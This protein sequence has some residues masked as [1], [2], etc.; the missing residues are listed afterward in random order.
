MRGR[1]IAAFLAGMG[2]GY[3]T[4]NE[5]KKDRERQ[6]KIDQ[7][8]FDKADREKQAYEERDALKQ[9]LKA[10]PTTTNTS[11]R[12]LSTDDVRGMTGG[13]ADP[14]APDYVS[15]EAAAHYKANVTG[16]DQVKSNASAYA[17]MGVGDGL[18]GQEVAAKDGKLEVTDP[19]KTK[20]IPAWKIMEQKAKIKIQSGIPEEEQLGFAGI[21]MAATEKSKAMMK[22]I[23]AAEKDPAKMLE[24]ASSWDNDDF[25]YTDLRLVEPAEKDGVYK[26]MGMANGKEELV[27]NYDPK[28][29]IPGMTIGDAIY[30]DVERLVQPQEL[31]KVKRQQMLDERAAEKEARDAKKDNLDLAGKE[32]VNGIN[33]K[34]LANAD[35]EIA[36][37]NQKDR[38]A[39]AASGES[40]ATSRYNRE[41]GADKLPAD[42]KTAMWYEKATPDQKAAFDAVKSKDPTVKITA[43]ALGGA[44][45]ASGNEIYQMDRQGNIKPIVLPKPGAKPPAAAPA[46]PPKNRPPLSS[47]GK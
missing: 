35:T 33:T 23:A 45:I 6:A 27:R 22:A 29:F 28:L 1:G 15:D 21:A 4:A 11:Q 8:T 7:I 37:S 36:L 12:E 40:A 41:T 25:K 14:M 19:S 38:A 39:I 46:A 20:D 2:T 24:V 30:K 16:P 44:T 17:Q 13:S 3:L 32:I 5:K 10:V 43:D 18:K 34:K 9:K 26:V 31:F 42:V 47:F